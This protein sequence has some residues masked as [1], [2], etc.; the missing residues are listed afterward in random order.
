[1]THDPMCRRAKITEV[2]MEGCPEC[3]LIAAVREDE[4][5]RLDQASFILDD[6][7]PYAEVYRKSR[8]AALR[9]AVAVMREHHPKCTEPCGMCAEW[10]EAINDIEALGDER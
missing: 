3:A 7:N 4:K 8:A 1:M 2:L 6:G 10:D 5:Q 9:D